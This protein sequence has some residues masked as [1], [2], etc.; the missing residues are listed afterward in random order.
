MTI[1]KADGFEFKKFSRCPVGMEPN[2]HR[3]FLDVWGRMPLMDI[4][5]YP[6]WEKGV[7]DVVLTNFVAMQ[8][9]FSHYTKGIPRPSPGHLEPE[10]EACP[11][12]EPE[13]GPE[14]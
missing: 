1:I 5:G 6:L 3:L 9:I 8:R 13:P 4:H 7:H 12:P 2:V 14:P 10:P 11:E